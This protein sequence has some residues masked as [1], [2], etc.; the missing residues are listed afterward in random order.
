MKNK[1]KHPVILTKGSHLSRLAILHHH[2]EVQHQ[3]RPITNGAMRQAGLW[4]V[5]LSR[6]V[7]QLLRKCITCH[8]F[9]GK[10]MQQLMAYLHT[11]RTD[12][13]PPFTNVGFNVI[14]PWLIRTKKLR[15]GNGNSE[16][17]GLVFTCRSQLSGCT[18]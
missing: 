6:M 1:E 14:G 15:K 17:W 7:N 8:R 18:Y 10:P 5:G 4:I 12:T 11:D 2:H 16:T 3:G 13:P 9:R